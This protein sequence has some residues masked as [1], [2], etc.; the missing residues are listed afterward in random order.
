MDFE[1]LSS[2]S[3]E[4]VQDSKIE[5]LLSI[6]NTSGLENRF[7]EAI[8]REL[9]TFNVTPEKYLELSTIIY[10]SQLDLINSGL[11]YN[12]TDIIRKLKK[13]I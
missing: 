2:D 8:Q 3:F 1:D 7:K 11:N 12:Q 5:Y 6:L 10:N 13:E 9:E 4:I